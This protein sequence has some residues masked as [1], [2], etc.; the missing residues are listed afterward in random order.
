MI[1]R[2]LLFSEDAPPSRGLWGPDQV[3]QS[4]IATFS[5]PDTGSSRVILVRMALN[6]ICF[7]SAQYVRVGEYIR[8]LLLV[9]S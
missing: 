1:L 4:K 8:I 5:P 2:D 3:L 9:F 6:L 7:L